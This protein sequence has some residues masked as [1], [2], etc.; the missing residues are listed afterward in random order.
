MGMRILVCSISETMNKPNIGK[1]NQG[2]QDSRRNLQLHISSRS[3]TL[4][5]I[6]I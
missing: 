1:S 3:G 5:S 4:E 6:A 2:N